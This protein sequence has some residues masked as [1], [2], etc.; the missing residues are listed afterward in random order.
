MGKIKD[1]GCNKAAAPLPAEQVTTP[2]PEPDRWVILCAGCGLRR[3]IPAGLKVGETFELVPCPRCS[4]TL[5]G[6]FTGDGV[7]ELL[8]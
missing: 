2:S 5:H 7:L 8:H 1:C 6:Q 3:L 4:N